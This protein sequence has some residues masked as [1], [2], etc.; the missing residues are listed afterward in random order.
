MPA[1]QVKP[2]DIPKWQVWEAYRR[3]AANK[4]APGADGQTLAA[5]ETDLKDNLYK[6]WRVMQNSP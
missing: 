5:F 4:G 1:S 3:V 2:F 6:V